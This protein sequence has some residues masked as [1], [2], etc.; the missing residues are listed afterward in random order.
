MSLSYIIKF[1]DL[2]PQLNVRNVNEFQDLLIYIITLQPIDEP[3]TTYNKL[4]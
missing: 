1:K 2:Q 3:L 4:T